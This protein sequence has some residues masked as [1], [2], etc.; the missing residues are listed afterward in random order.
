M[1]APMDMELITRDTEVLQAVNDSSGLAPSKCRLAMLSACAGET[2]RRRNS[3]SNNAYH[4]QH[5]TVPFG[6]TIQCRPFSG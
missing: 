3:Y 2:P 5:E 6:V 4:A 1:R